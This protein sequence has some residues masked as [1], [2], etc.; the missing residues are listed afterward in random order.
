M[1]SNDLIFSTWLILV[2]DGYVRESAPRG[3]WIFRSGLTSGRCF[4]QSVFVLDSC[5]R[6]HADCAEGE[7]YNLVMFASSNDYFRLESCVYFHI[8]VVICICDPSS[9]FCWL[10]CRGNVRL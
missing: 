9:K 8:C 5:L 10:A 7:G 4:W 2:F 3:D 1:N 6:L